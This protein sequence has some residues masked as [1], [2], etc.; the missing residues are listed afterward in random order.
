MTQ[1][2][3]R[4]SNVEP[5]FAIFFESENAY[6]AT[7]NALN[8]IK[9]GRNGAQIINNIINAQTSEKYVQIRATYDDEITN[10]TFVRLTGS[11]MNNYTKTLIPDTLPYNREAYK[12]ATNGE[13]VRPIVFYNPSHSISIN[14]AGEPKSANDASQSFVALAHELVHA[15][16]IIKGDSFGSDPRTSAYDDDEHLREEVRAIGFN[17][18]SNNPI[19][20]N[21]VRQDHNLPIRKFYFE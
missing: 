11:Q 7:E 6:L 4:M 17:M 19:S 8:K 5:N 3:G 9:S 15:Y 14:A 21:G 18:Y 13:G 20:E 10:S 2:I 12:F 16:H 1:F